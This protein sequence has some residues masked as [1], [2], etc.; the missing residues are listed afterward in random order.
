M[1]PGRATISTPSLIFASSSSVAD[2]TGQFVVATVLDENFNRVTMLATLNGQSQVQFVD[3]LGGSNL[4]T[5][6]QGIIVQ[7]AVAAGDVYAA[8]ADA[9]PLGVP[10][11]PNTMSNALA[12][13]GISRIAAVM[14]PAG[15]FAITVAIRAGTH[16]TNKPA[17]VNTNI[18]FFGQPNVVSVEYSVVPSFGE[19]T[20]P[21]PIGT[22]ELLGGTVS[23]LPEKTI[24]EFT[25]IAAQPNTTV[26]FG[27]DLV[28]A[29]NDLLGTT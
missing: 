20:F 23:I 18:E 19:L 24:L 3:P 25:T 28:L 14:I 16:S 7:G 10:S 11:A 6:V 22:T 8:L 9:A 12:G 1:V 17:N 21:V 15:K 4:V 27:T 29:D 26:F 2:N 5:W 13:I